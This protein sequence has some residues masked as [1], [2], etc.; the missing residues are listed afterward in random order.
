MILLDSPCTHY[1]DEIDLE[2]FL[3]IIYP[4]NQTDIINLKIRDVSDLKVIFQNNI[5]NFSKLFNLFGYKKYIKY[6]LNYQ[7]LFLSKHV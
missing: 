1:N 6:I 4:R 2:Y 7:L 5:V 3:M